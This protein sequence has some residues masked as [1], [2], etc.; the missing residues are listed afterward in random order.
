METLRAR[1]ETLRWARGADEPITEA[2]ARATTPASDDVVEIS[3]RFCDGGIESARF[4][5]H[6]SPATLCAA[7]WACEYAETGGADVMTLCATDVAEALHLA[8][9]Q[10]PAALMAVDALQA[11]YRRWQDVGAQEHQS[12]LTVSTV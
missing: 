3:L 4:R 9:I 6:G 10:M 11:A 2:T 5:T 7:D 8:R 1:F 12:Q